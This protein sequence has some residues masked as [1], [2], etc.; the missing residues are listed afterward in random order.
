MTS[1]TIEIPDALTEWVSKRLAAGHYS[2]ADAYVRDLIV[3][4]VEDAARA[5]EFTEA[6][7]E[8]RS[9]EPDRRS[10]DEIFDRVIADLNALA[11]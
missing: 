4:D 9:S 2:D 5:R 7:A 3:R 6:I 11:T 8:G 1:L 10:P